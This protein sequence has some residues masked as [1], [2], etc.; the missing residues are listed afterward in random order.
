MLGGSLS[1]PAKRWPALFGHF[2]LFHQYPYA[3]PGM[4]VFVLLSTVS[5]LCLFFLDEVSMMWFA[6][7]EH[8][9]CSVTP[10]PTQREQNDKKKS[11]WDHLTYDVVIILWAYGMAMSLGN[12]YTALVPLWAYTPVKL[13][14]LGWSPPLI[15]G[16]ISFAGLFQAFWLLVMMPILD[17]RIGTRALTRCCFAVWP[18]F[19]MVPILANRLAL[20]G[21]WTEVYGVMVTAQFAGAGVS[22]AFSKRCQDKGDALLNVRSCSHGP[23]PSQYLF[24]A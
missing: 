18:C 8:R 4:V 14:G 5:T 2:S 21:L 15:A 6:S 16:I 11:L 1:E 17:K 12:T 9:S 3:L 22:M 20:R 7:M 13:G 10:Q 23:A 24:A 19:F